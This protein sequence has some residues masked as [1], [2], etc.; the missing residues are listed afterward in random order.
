M[1][2]KN[3]TAL[4]IFIGAVLFLALELAIYYGLV[5]WIMPTDPY[6]EAEG[7]TIV[8]NWN[9]VMSFILAY[10]VLLVSVMLVASSQVPRSYKKHVM[11]WF[12]LSLP[13]L[14]IVLLVAFS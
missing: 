5:T 13:T 11:F 4:A 14:F 2:K 10:V 9:K 3:N 8:R 6:V 7:G 12:Y 1:Q